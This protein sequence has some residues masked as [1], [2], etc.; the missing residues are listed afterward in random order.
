MFCLQI[1]IYPIRVISFFCFNH[2][3]NTFWRAQ[4]MKLLIMKFVKNI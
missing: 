2:L 1:I 3:N 4:I